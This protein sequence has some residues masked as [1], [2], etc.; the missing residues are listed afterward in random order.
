ML[1]VAAHLLEKGYHLPAAATAGAVLEDS[2]R[3]LCVRHDVI[4][5]GRSGISV[6]NTELYKTNVYSGP[7]HGQIEAWSRLRNDVDHYN[8][9]N[10]DDID[11]NDVQRMVDGLRDFIVKYLT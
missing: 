5:D 8:F 7:T 1:E 9:T 2:L 11:A 6:L 10:P 4:F 3:K